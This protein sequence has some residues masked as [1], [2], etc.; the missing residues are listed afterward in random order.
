M[1]PEGQLVIPDFEC[2]SLDDRR[3]LRKMADEYAVLR[4]QYDS[5]GAQFDQA[6]NEE[7]TYLKENIES[8]TLAQKVDKQGYFEIFR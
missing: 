1:L 5:L 7:I 4:A 6:Q 3:R 2:A 8:V